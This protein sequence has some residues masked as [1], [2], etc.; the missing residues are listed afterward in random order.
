MIFGHQHFQQTPLSSYH[1]SSITPSKIIF[2]TRRRRRFTSVSRWHFW[3]MVV[4]WAFLR[5]EYSCSN[6][7]FFQR[8]LLFW[9]HTATCWGSK[10]SSTASRS[11]LS[12]SSLCP[13]LKF[14]SRTLTCSSVSL[15]FLYMPPPAPF[16]P[17]LILFFFRLR[18]GFFSPK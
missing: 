5:L 4:S 2:H 1:H 14:C 3:S 9:N 18:L 13:L 8:D 15:L 7:L 12:D 6:V 11:F 17:P 10:P 16:S